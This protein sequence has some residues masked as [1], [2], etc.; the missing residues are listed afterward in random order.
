MSTVPTRI[1]TLYDGRFLA[2]RLRDGWEYAERPGITGIVA[3]AAV[4]DEG[5]LVLVEQ[6]RIPV[7]RVVMELPAGL[8]GDEGPVGESLVEAARRELIEE[9][10]YD[11]A[12]WQQVAV[13]PP[14]PG[15]SNEVVTFYLATR[16]TR[17]GEGGGVDQENILV[18]EVALDEVPRWIAE[19]ERRGAYVDPKIYI[20]LFFAGRHWR[21]ANG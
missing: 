18:H 8:V 9:T 17:V 10:G 16:L 6:Y 21:K 3:I 5:R 14:S 12:D 1:K 15:L 4:T 13:G 7:Q 20:G 19:R 2:M 11:A